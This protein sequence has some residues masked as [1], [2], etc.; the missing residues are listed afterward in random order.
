[1][2]NPVDPRWT[3]DAAGQQM[4]ILYYE[5]RMRPLEYT[6]IALIPLFFVVIAYFA[7]QLR[8]DFAW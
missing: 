3:K 8:K 4:A 1:M 6:I 2:W 7:W 5:H